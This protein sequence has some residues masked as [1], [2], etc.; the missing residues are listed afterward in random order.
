MKKVLTFFTFSILTLLVISASAPVYAAQLS[1]D[2]KTYESAQT[3]RFIFQRTVFV[4]YKDGGAIADSLRGKE[5]T[6][7]VMADSS[8]PGIQHL[9]AEINESLARAK[10]SAVVTDAKVEYRASMT[11]RADFAS[12]DFRVVLTPTI[13]GFLIREYADGVPALFDVAWRGMK[14]D[15]QIPISTAAYGQLDINQPLSFFRHHFPEAAAQMVGTPAEGVLSMG[16]ID[17]S[18]I[19]NLPLTNWHFLF[20]PTGVSAETERFG[21]SG[22]RVVVSSFTMGESSFREGQVREKEVRAPFTS[23]RNYNV[24]TVEAGDSG[25]IFLSGFA[26]PDWLVDHE[27]VGV[28]AV[29]PTGAGQTSTGSFPIFIIYGMSGAAAA[30]AVGFFI[31]SSKKAKRESEFVQTGIDPKYLRGVTTSEAA[32]G[33]HTNRGEA[34]LASDDQSYKQHQSVYDSSSSSLED[35]QGS[36]PSSTRGSMPKGW[37]PS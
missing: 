18:G 3:P 12:V 14:I 32:G 19:G 9:I 31:W 16:L 20:D 6:A 30:G 4:D 22:A 24:R 10:S 25:N 26:S 2:A 8:T 21:F 33:Y 34:E 1:W 36:Q 7:T 37:K 5:F 13:D 17:A 35:S 15:S 23:D 11:G 27:V 28:S 29:A